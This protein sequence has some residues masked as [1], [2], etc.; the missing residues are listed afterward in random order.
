[1]FRSF[2]GA[3]GPNSDITVVTRWSGGVTGDGKV[4]GEDTVQYPLL[5]LSDPTSALAAAE[6]I[7]L[8]PGE[9]VISHI[10]DLQKPLLP[11]S[12]MIRVVIDNVVIASHTFLILPLQFMQGRQISVKEARMLHR[13]PSKP[14]ADADLSDISLHLNLGHGNSSAQEVSA[15]HSHLYGPQ[16]LKWIDELVARFYTVQDSCYIASQHV[17]EC[18]RSFLDPCAKTTWSSWSPDPKSHLG[19]VNKNTGR[20]TDPYRSG[21][22]EFR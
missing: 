21:S 15:T 12:W 5:V 9:Q 13:G 20:I 7:T 6:K 3:L 16:L 17:P 8:E 18:V 11:G 4:A 10:F 22:G 19:E 2:G 14:Y 1:V